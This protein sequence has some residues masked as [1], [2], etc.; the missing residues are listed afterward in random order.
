MQTTSNKIAACL[1]GI[2]NRVNNVEEYSFYN[3]A[4]WLHITPM[5]EIYILEII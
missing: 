1:F 4:A 5:H 3:A 2:S